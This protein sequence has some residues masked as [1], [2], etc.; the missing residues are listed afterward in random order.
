MP[1]LCPLECF[2]NVS[3]LGNIYRGSKVGLTPKVIS[4]LNISP[5]KLYSIVLGTTKHVCI[6]S[7][8]ENLCF[9]SLRSK[10]IFL[11]SRTVFSCLHSTRFLGVQSAKSESMRVFASKL[12]S[13]T[14]EFH[15]KLEA[16]SKRK[17]SLAIAFAYGSSSS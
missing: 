17:L 13:T 7:K 2:S 10:S 16:L 15:W 9:R 1:F 8:L 11:L 12:V 6:F 4:F 14:S 5:S 3:R